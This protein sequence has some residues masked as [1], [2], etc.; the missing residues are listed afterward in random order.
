MLEKEKPQTQEAHS[1]GVHGVD[2][3]ICLQSV[4]DRGF[5]FNH[6]IMIIRFRSRNLVLWSLEN[7]MVCENPGKGLVVQGEDVSR[8]AHPP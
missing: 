1:C 5:G 6:K 4:L 7:L 3:Q 2:W 8:L